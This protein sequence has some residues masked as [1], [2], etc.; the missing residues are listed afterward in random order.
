MPACRHLIG[1]QVFQADEIN[2][3]AFDLGRLSGRV[4]L[5]KVDARY[6][7]KDLNPDWR[8]PH[9][10]DPVFLKEQLLGELGQVEAEFP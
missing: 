1:L 7:C 10:D 8:H 5:V 2:L 4:A 6:G 3:H 9:P